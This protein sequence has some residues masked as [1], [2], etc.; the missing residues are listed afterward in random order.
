LGRQVKIDIGKIHYQFQSYVGTTST[1]I[2]AGYEMIRVPS[3]LKANGIAWYI[4]AGG[5][6]GQMHVQR[7]VEMEGGPSKI[8]ATDIDMARLN[9]VKERV[10][11]AS[12]AKGIEVLT[13]NPND[14]DKAEFDKLLRDFTGGRGFDDIIILAP[15]VS[16]IE[17][18]IQYLAEE[19]LMNIF[20]GFPVGT[21]ANLDLTGVY[22][23][24]IRLVGS[25][26]SRIKDMLDT[27]HEAESGALATDKS[28]AAIGGIEASW[29]GMLATK[30]GRF[31]GKIIIYPQISGLELVAVADLKSR[32]PNV[33]AKLTDGI[34]WNREAEKELLRTML[35]I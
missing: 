16:L 21:T 15:V 17:E 6:M 18:A 23:K 29:D 26:G 24:K 1:R 33:Y 30:E 11:S 10:M 25:S 27:L 3:E 7:A 34:F 28:V 35:K 4:G 14:L 22:E 13:V 9:S 32:L 2:G 12:A 20:A 19:G 5:P 8:L 31:P